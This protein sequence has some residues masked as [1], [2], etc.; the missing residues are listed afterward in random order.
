MRRNR[1]KTACASLAFG[2]L[3][4]LEMEIQPNAQN[5]TSKRKSQKEPPNLLKNGN[6]RGI[7]TKKTADRGEDSGEL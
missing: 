6:K 1:A 4:D 2:A 7:L 5:I 3:D